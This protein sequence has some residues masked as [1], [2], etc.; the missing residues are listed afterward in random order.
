MRVVLPLVAVLI[1]TLLTALA[2]LLATFA[3]G[4]C[5]CSRPIVVA[6]PYATILWSTTN[7]ESLGGALLA[8]Q[9]PVY[10]LLV[11]IAKSRSLRVRYALILLAIHIAADVVGLWFYR[12]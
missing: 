11:A 7:R 10:A 3:T 6:F 1:G 9:F 8:F 5:N 12:T 4:A 2:F